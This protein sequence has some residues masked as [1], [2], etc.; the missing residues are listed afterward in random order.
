M[1]VAILGIDHEIQNAN[2]WRS[3]GLKAAYRNLLI[4]MIGQRGV[5]FIGEEAGPRV[6]V[7][8][9]LTGAMGLQYPWR[10]IGMS[11]QLRKAAGIFVE[12]RD[13]VS[14]PRVGT[15]QS[16]LAADGFYLDLQNGS[17][18][19][20]P[21]VPSD[22]VREDYML[23]RA[24][25]GAAGADSVLILVGNLHVEELANRFTAHGDTATTD[26]LYRHDWYNP[27]W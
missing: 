3:E 16:H 12:Q 11:E 8:A 7:G 2:A 15:V 20:T 10:N 21:R 4:E 18:S 9:Q 14:V 26:A 17:H 13:R 19:Y 5:Q 23:D 1:N 22:S 27:H 6:T 24:L 25:E